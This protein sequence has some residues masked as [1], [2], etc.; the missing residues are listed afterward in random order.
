MRG[1]AGPPALAASSTRNF[2]AGYSHLPSWKRCGIRCSVMS[3]RGILLHFMP[4]AAS[5]SSTHALRNYS[6]FLACAS[7]MATLAL[8]QEPSC[9]HRQ[10]PVNLV[11]QWGYPQREIE[12]AAFRGDFRGKPIEILRVTKDAHPRRIIILLDSSGSMLETENR[13]WMLALQVAGDAAAFLP[14]DTEV[15]LDSFA[16]RIDETV[17]FGQGRNAVAEKIIAWKPGIN[18]GH[19]KRRTTAL[20]DSLLEAL[21]R[22]G[23]S[24]PGDVVYLISD[25]GDNTSK[26]K[27][28][29]VESAYIRAGVRL[30]SFVPMAESTLGL[31]NPD[32]MGGA[33]TL[34]DLTKSTGGNLVFLPAGGKLVLRNFSLG[35]KDKAALAYL[36]RGLYMQMREFY[37]LEMTLPQ[38]VDKPHDWLLKLANLPDT[39]RKDLQLRYPTKLFPCSQPAPSN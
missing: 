36:L 38:P 39:R 18:P 31:T 26:T 29:A 16:E 7:L 1:N 10:V 37:W 27:P 12:T 33:S 28:Q 24:Q 25:G 2:G 5:S 21:D 22:F 9:L 3:P 11:D 13:K 34:Q 32:E 17:D 23:R 6:L 19:S 30:F 20:W 4:A 14:P 15:A 8:A 35:E